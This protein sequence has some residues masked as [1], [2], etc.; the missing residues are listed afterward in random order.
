[1]LYF[2]DWLCR[3]AGV[4]IKAE[5]SLKGSVVEIDRRTRVAKQV[6]A[7]FTTNVGASGFAVCAALAAIG[8]HAQTTT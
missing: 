2:A 3:V 5:S 6:A 4:T 1:M 7:T 8:A